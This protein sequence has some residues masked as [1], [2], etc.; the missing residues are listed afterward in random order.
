MTF[1]LT[2]LPVIADAPCPAEEGATPSGVRCRAGLA[3]GDTIGPVFG[4][5]LEYYV[6]AAVTGRSV[7]PVVII[8][9]FPET[10]DICALVGADADG[11]PLD[12]LEMGWRL[13]GFSGNLAYRP[14]TVARHFRIMPDEADLLF[15]ETMT[16]LNTVVGMDGQPVLQAGRD[17]L[18]SWIDAQRARWKADAQ[19]AIDAHDLE[20][21]GAP[22]EAA[23]G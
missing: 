12:A 2:R 17:F 7:S 21:I 13:M 14:E 15:N 5:V 22:A 9:N 4:I 3:W 16:V 10:E 11:A 8:D 1:D 6:G 23:D 18:D 20:V 19:S